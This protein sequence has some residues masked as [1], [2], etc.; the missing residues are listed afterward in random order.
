V[1]RIK[2]AA[3][4][5]ALVLT[6]AAA[7]HSDRDDGADRG[8]RSGPSRDI[9]DTEARGSDRQDGSLERGEVGG[10]SR[11]SG[12][13]DR[14]S[15]GDSGD[16]SDSHGREEDRAD[17]GPRDQPSDSGDNRGSSG[18]APETTARVDDSGPGSASSG[19]SG[20]WHANVLVDRDF[21]GAERRR[22]EVL[23]LG[24]TAEIEAAKARGFELISERPLASAGETIARLRVP[25]GQ[26][27][28]AAAAVIKAAAPDAAVGP[29]Y[30]FRP[31]AG[32]V[33]RSN[34][35]ARR[36]LPAHRHGELGVVDTGVDSAVLREAIEEQRAF[37]D[38]GPHPQEHGAAVVEIAARAG[39]NV[40]LAD[41]FDVDEDGAP[42]ASADAIARGV[43][44]L[45]ARGMSVINISNEGPPSSVLERVVSRAVSEGVILVAAAG[46]SG[47][48]APPSYP[49]A[50]DGVIAVTAVDASGRVYR[51]ANRGDYVDFAAF[52]VRVPVQY[53]D[54]SPQSLS[55]TSYASPLV[56]ADIAHRLAHAPR[57]PTAIE[58]ELRAEAID[59][60]PSGRDPIYGWGKLAVEAR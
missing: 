37:G 6:M 23:M 22:G 41:V 26:T 12:G 5:V 40:V 8:D 50:F 10:S 20:R 29:N 58:S 49:A 21:S 3:A 14:H 36:A 42:V 31:S 17:R 38:G 54:V 56:A 45:A 57:S 55:G 16:R 24:R 44:W 52:G 39:S 4:T 28:E 33:V 25:D 18:G 11:V 2:L 43:D 13:E 27:L 1:T 32:E 7:A 9:R 51:R 60:G 34:R 15:S 59:L 48:N 47:P 30:V 19:G 46:N 35:Q 53:A